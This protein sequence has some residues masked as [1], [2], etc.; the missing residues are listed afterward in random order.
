MKKY[1]APLCG[2]TKLSSSDIIAV[3]DEI[4]FGGVFELVAVSESAVLGI[5][6]GFGN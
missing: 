1:S 5:D 2:V 6:D 3:S 4:R